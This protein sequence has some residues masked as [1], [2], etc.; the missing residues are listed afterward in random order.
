MPLFQVF[1]QPVPRQNSLP[2]TLL[3]IRTFL[4]K[5]SKGIADADFWGI[6]KAFSYRKDILWM[7]SLHEYAWSKCEM[8]V[9][10]SDHAYS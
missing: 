2:N 7:K 1:A 5:M 9:S 3:P 10:H 8:H 4:T 6:T